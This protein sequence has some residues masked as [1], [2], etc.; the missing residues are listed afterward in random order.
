VNFA[1]YVRTPILLINGRNDEE[2][3]WLGRG[4]PLWNLLPEPKKLVLVDGAGHIPPD[5][6]RIPAI[7]G[8]LDSV[9]GPVK[10]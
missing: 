6:A 10:R 3:T 9:F 7:N 2:H 4:L 8:W 1:P 5:E